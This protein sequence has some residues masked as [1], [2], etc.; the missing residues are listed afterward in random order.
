MAR[1]AA[2][3]LGFHR[4]IA[5]AP[6]ARQVARHLHRPV[7]GRQQ[8]DHQRHP[9]AGDRRDGGRGRTVP[10]RGSRASAPPPPRSRSAPTSRTARRNASAP[11]RRAGGAGSTAAGRAAASANSSAPSCGERGLAGERRREPV[12][13]ASPRARR[14]RDRAIR[15]L[16]RRRRNIDPVAP[17]RAA[18][19]VHGSRSR[20]SRAMP[21]RQHA[22]GLVARLDLRIGCSASA[23]GAEPAQRGGRAGLRSR[24]RTRSRRGSRCDRRNCASISASVER[25][26]QQ[27]CGPARR[28]RRSRR[29]RETARAT[30]PTPDRRW[31][32]GRWRAGR[33]RRR[34]GSW[35]CGPDRR[36]PAARRRD[37]SR[38]PRRA[39]PSPAGRQSSAQ[40]FAIAPRVLRRGASGRGAGRRGGGARSTS[41]PPRPRS[42]STT[43]IS[44]A[45]AAVAARRARRPPC[46]RAAAAAAVAAAPALRR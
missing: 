42:V 24:R 11:R 36:A 38:L 3:H 7:R 6:E 21:S 26:G 40:R 1:I 22:R 12:A 17:L 14:R 2:L 29:P 4:R 9:A 44:A 43:A 41:L 45:S 46:A 33:R 28:C 15:R 35:R 30:A 31:R 27:R 39:L 19:C 23:I 18:P 32:R 34:R 10:A 20:P 25:R 16:R 5:A 37:S 8:L 13:G